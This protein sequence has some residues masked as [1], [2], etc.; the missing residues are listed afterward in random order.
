MSDHTPQRI[1]EL[2]PSLPDEAREALTEIAEASAGPHRALELTPEERAAL[3]ASFADFA[4][5][6]VLDEA[7]YKREMDAFMRKLSART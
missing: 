2:W 1:L 5:G 6:R 3:A 7:E 4:A